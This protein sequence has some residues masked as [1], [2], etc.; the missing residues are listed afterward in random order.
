MAAAWSSQIGRSG[1][2]WF[3][4]LAQMHCRPRRWRAGAASPS[5]TDLRPLRRTALAGALVGC[6]VAGL[7]A[8]A[9]GS[10]QARYA[11]LVRGEPPQ[12]EPPL[13]GKMGADFAERC[14]V[15]SKLA[16]QP[17]PA[18]ALGQRAM[19]QEIR[20]RVSELSQGD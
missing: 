20:G 16:R 19:G 15:V 10:T 14:R 1:A 7:F 9:F 4:W 12:V 2:E 18:P 6:P 13:F 17:R 8:T 3:A 5:W 11:P